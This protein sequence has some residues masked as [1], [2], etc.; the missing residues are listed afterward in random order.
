M[1]NDVS[2]TQQVQ[3]RLGSQLVRIGCSSSSPRTSHG[4]AAFMT[5]CPTYHI[6]TS[7]C[8]NGLWI[9]LRSVFLFSRAL[10]DTAQTHSHS[11]LSHNP[12]KQKVTEALPLQKTR[13][14]VEYPASPLTRYAIGW[15]Y[16]PVAQQGVALPYTWA[17]RT[18][19]RRWT[20]NNPRE[21]CHIGLPYYV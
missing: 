4:N 8:P 17:H 2:V 10:L 6:E 13:G 16:A 21:H 3:R 14:G 18:G 11:C 20:M 9:S 19:V 12:S 5:M 7:K 1:R 15:G